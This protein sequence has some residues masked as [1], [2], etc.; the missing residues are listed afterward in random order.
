MGTGAMAAILGMDAQKVI[1]GCA[2]V[3]RSFRRQQR[4]SGGG[5]E[6]QRSDADRDRRQQ[7]RGREGLRSAQGQRRQ[8]RA[9]A[10]GVGA[11]P[12]EPDEAGGRERCGRSWRR[13]PSPRRRFR[14]STTSKWQV[15]TDPDRIRDALYEQAFGPVR[16]VECVQA[17]KARG[18]ATHRR[19]RP[20]Q[21]AGRHVPSAS[22]PS[23][24]R[25][26][27]YDPATLAEAQRAAGMTHHEHSHSK[28][29]S[30]WSPALRAAS[31]RRSRSNWR[32]A[33]SRSS[34][35]APP[36]RA[37]P[38]SPRRSAPMRGRGRRA[39]RQR[40]RRRSKRWS[41]PSSRSTAACT[42]WSTTPA[43][44]ATCSPCA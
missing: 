1:A 44:P 14:W 7:G 40:R 9:A 35:P 39:R 36:T 16:W 15:E 33:A 29:R 20:G 31:A 12:F 3:V 21:G 17:I 25:A 43:S 24:R 42:C 41:T 30:R 13:S 27:L 22:T 34:A 2:E 19:M 8:A 4:R 18:V 11:V 23:W 28:A 32:S 26:S 37:R 5:R 10:A 38:R 6:L